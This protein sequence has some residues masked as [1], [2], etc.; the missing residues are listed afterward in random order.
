MNAG[1]DEALRGLV[2]NLEHFP[3]TLHRILR[4]RGSW[5]SR[6]TARALRLPSRKPDATSL[7]VNLHIQFR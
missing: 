5:R 2:V 6:E 3:F 1:P 7:V 4:R